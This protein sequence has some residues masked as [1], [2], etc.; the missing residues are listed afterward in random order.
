MKLYRYV[1]D[2]EE[3]SGDYIECLCFDVIRETPQTYVVDNNGKDRFI[4]KTNNGKRFAYLSKSIAFKSY[5]LRKEAQVKLLSN[6]LK[7]AKLRLSCANN[8]NGK[9]KHKPY[10]PNPCDNDSIFKIFED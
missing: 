8:N 9:I 7:F 5:I 10:I 2:Y 4:L 6:Q 1:D 3:Y